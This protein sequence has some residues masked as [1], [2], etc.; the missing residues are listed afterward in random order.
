M[1]R[2]ILISSLKLFGVLMALILVLKWNVDI[3]LPSRGSQIFPGFPHKPQAICETLKIWDADAQTFLDRQSAQIGLF[4]EA[5]DGVLA[6]GFSFVQSLVERLVFPTIVLSGF[7]ADAGITVTLILALILVSLGGGIMIQWIGQLL[8]T[9]EAALPVSAPG[10]ER[11]KR[12]LT[13]TKVLINPLKEANS[14]VNRARR[15]GPENGGSD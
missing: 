6:Q 5:N 3:C 2:S 9:A 1:F 15:D 7:P 4:S 12:R 14:L 10:P 11:K 8:R 13:A